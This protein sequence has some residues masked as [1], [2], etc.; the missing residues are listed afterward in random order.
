[1]NLRVQAYFL[2]A[3]DAYTPSIAVLLA[4]LVNLVGDV[5]LC[6]GF[7]LGIAGAAWA[8]VAAQVRPRGLRSKVEKL[9]GGMT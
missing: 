1:M 8:T 4:G 5:T 9:T 3:V 6:F 7:G 2:A